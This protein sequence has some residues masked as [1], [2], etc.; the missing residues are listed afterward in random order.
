V[1]PR[2]SWPDGKAFAF[3]VFDDPDS[4]TL[5]NGRPVYALLADLGFRTTKAV[6]PI[7]GAGTPSDHGGTCAEDDYREWAQS[8]QA[9]GFEI[10]YHNATSHTSTREETIRGLDAFAKYFGQYPAAMANHYNCAEG[11]YWGDARLTGLRRALYNVVTRGRNRAQSFGHVAGHPCFWGDLC[12][13]RI[14]YVRNFVFGQT[15]TLRAC[16]Y[17]PYHDPSRPYVNYWYAASEGAHAPAFLARIG[18]ADQDRLEAE[19]GACIMYTHFGHGYV[20]GDGLNRRFVALMERLSRKNGWFVPVSTLLDYL[21][22][23]RGD[24]VLTGAQRR[25]LERRWLWRKIRFGTA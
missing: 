19:G 3:T 22:T 23:Q 4:Q 24:P 10:A 6:W 14:K 13:Q 16:P 8:L 12:R 17:L 15:N 9:Q 21:L 18:E 7:R 5:E 20:D 1:T 2:I 11:I 25:E